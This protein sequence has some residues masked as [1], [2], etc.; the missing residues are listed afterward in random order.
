[1]TLI[2]SISGIRGTLGGAIGDSLSPFDLVKYTSAF[3]SWLLR[4]T[5]HSS[6]AASNAVVVGRDA[7][8]SGEAVSRVVIG[9]LQMLG[10]DVVDLELSTTPTV[11][12]AVTHHQAL[13]GIVI[14]ASHNPEN[15]NALKLLNHRG[16]FISAADGEAVLE[17][18]LKH[19]FD[20]TEASK[21]GRYYVDSYALDRHIAQIV[22]LEL[23]DVEAIRAKQFSIAVDAVNSSGGIAV[24]EL[25]KALGLN[26]VT[27]INGEPTGKFAHDPEPLPQ[28]L[29]EL[30]D[31]LRTGRFDLGIAVDPDVDRLVFACEDGQPFGEEFT[32]VAIA[33]YVLQHQPGSNTVSNLS[34]TVALRELTLR[35]G[36]QY[37]ASAVGE[38]NVVSK[39]KAI[40]ACIGGEGNGGVIYPELH[41]G[42]DALVG[43]ALFLSYLAQIDKLPSELRS[44]YPGYVIAK[45]KLALQPGTSFAAI[46]EALSEKYKSHPVDTTDGIKIEFG[47]AW[48][49]L[50]P[51]N[52]EP[53][54]RIYAE[55]ENAVL[56]QELANQLVNDIME[57]FAAAK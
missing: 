5:N 10:L 4:T 57:Y 33:D 40:Q 35:Q 39:M 53:V 20:Y 18:A 34:S 9:T 3:G 17:Q 47:V 30:H 43:I 52:T 14:T 56:A 2:K 51:S 15:W 8:L 12:L 49:H 26:E 46:Y 23:V 41:Y 48:V 11:E 21:I 19:A 27:L 44:Q 22:A 6:G 37:A 1:M 50:R 54:V 7:R 55:A 25:L 31:L 13:G 16:E 24:P 29:N 36:G 45:N 28:H 42:R 32:L 38:V